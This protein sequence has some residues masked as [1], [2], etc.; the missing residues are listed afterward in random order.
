MPVG[1]EIRVTVLH[2]AF[3]LIP[4]SKYVRPL[5]RLNKER[6]SEHIGMFNISG[7]NIIQ[8]FRYT[9]LLR[10]LFLVFARLMILILI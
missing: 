6:C 3:F 10:R 5:P 7:D 1:E 4:I 8:Y 2:K 9:K